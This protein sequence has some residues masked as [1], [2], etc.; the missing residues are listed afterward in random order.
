MPGVLLE[1][2]RGRQLPLTY[3]EATPSVDESGRGSLLCKGTKKVLRGWNKNASPSAQSSP[4]FTVSS[5]FICRLS[6]LRFCQRRNAKTGVTELGRCPIV[7]RDGGFVDSKRC[8][9]DTLIPR[10]TTSLQ[11]LVIFLFGNFK[12]SV[13]QN[14][15]NYIGHACI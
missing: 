13:H 14:H 1:G 9:S 11:F 10:E 15:K 7:T 5:V 3:G 4:P 12:G 8:H 2:G 6:R